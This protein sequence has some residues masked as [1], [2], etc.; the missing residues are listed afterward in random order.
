[1]SSRASGSRFGRSVRITETSIACFGT[2]LIVAALLANQRW[3]DRH[4]LPDFFI[5]RE[6]QVRVET[7]TRIAVAAVGLAL[8]LALRRPLARFLTDDPLR[9]LLIALA[10]ISSFGLAEAILRGAHVRAKEEVPAS[11]EP[12]RHLDAKLGWLFVPSHT[13]Y[14]TSHGRR[15]EYA[16]D[17]NGY[18]VRSAESAVDFQQPTIVFTGES[19]MVG[20]KLPWD[21]TIPAQTGSL[22]HLQ[23][24]NIAV[25]GFANDQAYLRLKSELSRFS[26]PVAVVTLFSP[27]LFDRN[28]DDDRPGLGPGLTWHPAQNRSRLMTIARRLIRYRSDEAI[29]RGVAAT[30]DVLR[31]GADLARSK[32]AVPLIVV[33][34]FGEEQPRERAL[35]HRILDEARLPYVR[36]PLDPT[37]RVHDDGHPDARGARAIAAAIAKRLSLSVHKEVHS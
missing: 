25:S 7:N 23:S 2:A 5:S 1:M 28:L 31:A 14:Q 37:W 15:V 33:P 34:Q 18:R 11:M 8:A 27:A 10:V 4:F 3:L 21:E 19:V 13:G 16:F 26:H 24:A 29:E 22:L 6:T 35:R 36:V 20:E 30:Q 9:T 17:R 32:G 12:R